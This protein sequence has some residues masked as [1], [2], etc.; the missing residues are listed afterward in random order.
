M[1]IMPI[2]ARWSILILSFIG[3]A[4]ASYI[5]EHALTGVP[6]VCTIGGFDGC[7]IVEQSVY[8]HV[9]GVP[10]SLY[11]MVFYV[12]L[13]ILAATTLVWVHHLIIRII[14]IVAVLGVLASAIFVA[15]QVFLIGALCIYCMASA[16]VTVLILI[17]AFWRPKLVMPAQGAQ[18]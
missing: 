16:T 1:N 14:R 11:G 9:F 12:L 10:L 2:L 8:S 15:I 4:D 13:F 18:A 7:R 6:A 5:T 3:L 17:A